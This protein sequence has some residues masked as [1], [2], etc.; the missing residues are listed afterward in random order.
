[1]AGMSAGKTHL[2]EEFLNQL[3]AERN[4]DD[5][6]YAIIIDTKPPEESDAGNRSIPRD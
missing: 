1:M 6:P 3:L 2:S 4:Q 5:A